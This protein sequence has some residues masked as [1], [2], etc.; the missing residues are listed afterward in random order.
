MLQVLPH[1][2]DAPNLG[3]LSHFSLPDNDIAP[4]I[5]TAVTLGRPGARGSTFPESTRRSWRPPH[6]TIMPKFLRHALT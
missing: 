2:E 1:A 6:P 3:F 5:T 4:P